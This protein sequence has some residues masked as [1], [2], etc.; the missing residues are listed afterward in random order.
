[1]G[2]S[3]V[4]FDSRIIDAE[5]I[6]TY[7]TIEIST[8]PSIY[9]RPSF[10]EHIAT[11]PI[12]LMELLPDDLKNMFDSDPEEDQ[13]FTMVGI[14][15]EALSMAVQPPNNVIISKTELESND[16]VAIVSFHLAAGPSVSMMVLPDNNISETE[17][18]SNEKDTIVSSIQSFL[19]ELSLIANRQSTWSWIRGLRPKILSWSNSVLLDIM[20]H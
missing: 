15:T 11:S 9:T 14:Q 10:S 16:K 4:F 7:Q 19:L 1:M 6:N 12:L 17:L 18:E 8:G 2:Q 3:Y 20:H 5:C 13:D